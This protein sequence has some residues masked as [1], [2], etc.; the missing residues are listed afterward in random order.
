M[1]LDLTNSNGG[2]HKVTSLGLFSSCSEAFRTIH[3]NISNLQPHRQDISCLLNRYLKNTF[4][5]W[6]D[7]SRV[8]VWLGL[9]VFYLCFHP[10]PCAALTVWDYDL[11]SFMCQIPLGRSC[12]SGN[13]ASK[14]RER[15][16]TPL[17]LIVLIVTLLFAAVHKDCGAFFGNKFYW[18]IHFISQCWVVISYSDIIAFSTNK[19]CNESQALFLYSYS[20]NQF[21]SSNEWNENR[22]T[23]WVL[24]DS[25]V[26]DEA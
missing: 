19:W 26:D 16:Q 15:S 2:N 4:V 20:S 13:Y 6:S 8:K 14:W 3:S 10:L 23:L 12:L 24:F 1:N 5:L 25:C 22:M 17:G 9:A 7:T 11:T 21:K 18:E